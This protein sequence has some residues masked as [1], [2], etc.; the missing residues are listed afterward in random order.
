MVKKVKK[1]KALLKDQKPDQFEQWFDRIRDTEIFPM[2]AVGMPAPGPD[3][4]RQARLFGDDTTTLVDETVPDETKKSGKKK[5]TRV[6]N[7]GDR[8]QDLYYQA[9]RVPGFTLPIVMKGDNVKPVQFIPGHIWAQ[10]IEAINEG[11]E[12]GTAVDGPHAAKVMVIGKMPGDDEAQLKRYFVGPTGNLLDEILTSLQVKGYPSWYV[13]NVLK[14][15][16][17]DGSATIKASWLADCMPLMHQELRLVRPD[18][19]LCL[20]SDAIQAILGKKASVTGM[21]GRVE[22][23]TY[24][25]GV[26]DDDPRSKTALVMGVVHPAAV[27]RDEALRR[28]LERGIARFNLLLQG[29]R[30]D[31]EET[32]V[33]HRVITDIDELRQ[34]LDEIELDPGKT[35][36]MIAVDAEWNG[37]H[38]QNN[39]SYL[40]TVQFSWKPKHAFAVMLRD[41]GGKTAAISDRN[42]KPAIGKA[43]RMLKQFIKGVD[44]SKVTGWGRPYRR[45]RVVGHFATADLEWLVAEGLDI[46]DEFFVPLY[47]LDLRK[48]PDKSLVKKYKKLGWSRFVP[49]WCRTKYEGG[50]DTGYAAH[51]CEE[52]AQLGLETLAIRYTSAPRYDLPLADWKAKYCKEKKIK[53]ADLDG[54]GEV[55]NYILC[56]TPSECKEHGT[57]NYACYDADVTLRLYYEFQ[58]LLDKG[59]VGE[60]CREAFWESM[61]AMPGILEINTTGVVIDR[62]RIDL[63]TK[64]F[65]A[66]R[67]EL[68]DSIRKKFNWPQFNPRSTQQ[69]KEFLFG[70]ELNGKAFANGKPVRLRP[71]GAMSIGVQPLVNTGKPPRKWSELVTKGIAHEHSPS[72]NKQ[73]LAILRYD[74]EPVEEYIGMLFDF[75][76][77]D[78]ALKSMLRPPK[79][80]ASNEWVHNED[81]DLEYD[82]GL[83]SH[84]CDDGRAR[85]HL[86][87]TT[88]TGRARS[89]RPNMQNFAKTRD[90]DYGRLTGAKYPLRSVVTA[91]PGHLFVE[92]DFV[93]AE[94]AIMAILSGDRKMIDHAMR[95]QLPEDDPRYYDIHSNVACEA[96]RLDC[97]PT[98][99]GLKSIG[100]SHLRIVAK[101]V[102]FGV[103]YGRG[104]SAVAMAAREQGISIT[105]QDAENVIASI[106]E[107]YP[108]L[109]LLFDDAEKRATKPRWLCTPFG[110]FRRFPATQD[111]TLTSDFA[112]QA[113]NFPIQSAVAS[114]IGRG[115][116]YLID[117]RDDL[118]EPDLFK[119]TLQIHDALLLEASI[120]N[121]QYVAE[122]LLPWALHDRVEIHP[123][124]LA[125]ISSSDSVYRLG[126]DAQIYKHWGVPLTRKEAMA[127][128]LTRQHYAGNGI[129][130]KYWDD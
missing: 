59:Y 70:E 13:T 7:V 38:P 118:G 125:G 6:A 110:R 31:K 72:T 89:A 42:G 86:Y 47:D 30:F 25:T 8:L 68:L 5:V 75:R 106:F 73:S 84:I 52:T 3:F 23:F 116:A 117:A 104:A 2:N 97:E 124:T 9:L 66:A 102:I 54:Y 20:G 128:G 53:A 22:E 37:N 19:I 101:S 15:R 130:V 33:D 46:R 11:M 99:S 34:T 21:D 92:A 113:K 24:R 90:K 93:G 81:G 35:D 18:F 123:T 40:R 49:A 122:H 129:N 94:L 127:L 27:L 121:I 74:N 119:V 114:A 83:A 88:E 50:F 4:I 57:L 103:A 10:H 45:K 14:F 111:K 62:K 79:T 76:I 60:N 17:P 26:Y 95:N 51:A 61:I 77:L 16:P 87:L 36:D 64:D 108:G 56:P 112:R 48:C 91:A 55:P 85:T 107:A 65:L 32:D 1:T 29:R 44:E 12:G 69:V 78:Q 39:D 98:K 100:K 58:N 67:D 43:I 41:A 28:Q 126:L 120:D 115:M 80:D 96:F 109:T 71:E 105:T 82:A 63:L